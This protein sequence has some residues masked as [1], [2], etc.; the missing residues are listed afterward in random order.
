G[1]HRRYGED[2]Q[3]GP[4]R[5][6]AEKAHPALRVAHRQ[7]D[8]SELRGDDE[9][10][11]QKGEAEPDDRGEIET[12]PGFRPVDIPAQNVLVIAKPVIAPKSHIVAEES[13]PERVSHCLR[14]DR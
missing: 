12:Q 8:P 5:R 2:E 3:F 7:E 11:H 4:G 9:P 14:Y 6:I 1:E 13:E 10:A